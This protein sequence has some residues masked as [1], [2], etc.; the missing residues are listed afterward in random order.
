MTDWTP[1]PWVDCFAADTTWVE[2]LDDDVEICHIGDLYQYYPEPI[3]ESERVAEKRANARLIAKAPEMAELL[4]V[5]TND[6]YP[7]EEYGERGTKW[8]Y[9]CDTAEALLASLKGKPSEVE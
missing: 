7:E 4:E 1:G 9:I 6:L 5:I 3:H 2:S 8:G